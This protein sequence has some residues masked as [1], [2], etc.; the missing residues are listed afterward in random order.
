MDERND[1]S[2]MSN[3][4]WYK[5]MGICPE[6][7]K[8]P[9]F[10]G[11]VHCEYC[12]EKLQ[13]SQFVYRESRKEQYRAYS[14]DSMKRRYHRLKEAGIC[15][16][17]GKKPAIPGMTKCER[18]RRID[19]E[20]SSM[21]QRNRR[22]SLDAGEKFRQKRAAGLCVFCGKPQAEGTAFC[23]EHLK[24]R[25]ETIKVAKMKSRWRQAN[26]ESYKLMIAT[27]KGET[28]P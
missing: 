1:K 2:S 18:C 15:V 4:Q 3:Y 10:G 21:R 17:C 26:D 28:K 27:K 5:S 25:R 12:M 7:G 19:N 13:V 8:R 6:C 11:F 24:T 20:R 22:E 9:S 14:R 23:E 16:R